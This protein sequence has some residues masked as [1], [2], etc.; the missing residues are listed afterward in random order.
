MPSFD[1][2][3]SDPVFRNIQNQRRGASVAYWLR[4]LALAFFALCVVLAVIRGR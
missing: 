1:G 3:P 2:D 4:M